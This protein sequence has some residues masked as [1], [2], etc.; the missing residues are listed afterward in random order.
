VDVELTCSY[1]QG[2]HSLYTLNMTARE[3]WTL[4]SRAR[5]GKARTRIEPI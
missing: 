5:T 1:G 4:N 3:K 2:P